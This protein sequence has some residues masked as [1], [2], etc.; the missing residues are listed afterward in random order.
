MMAMQNSN[1]IFSRKC[2]YTNDAA[3]SLVMKLQEWYHIPDVIF[4]IYGS[5]IRVIVSVLVTPLNE[6]RRWQ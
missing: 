3:S 5:A 6:G 2:F 4:W 1:K